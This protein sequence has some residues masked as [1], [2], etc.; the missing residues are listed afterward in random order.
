MVRHVTV[1]T[2]CLLV[3]AQMSSMKAIIKH[4]TLYEISKLLIKNFF[5]DYFYN[6]MYRVNIIIIFIDKRYLMMAERSDV[7]KLKNTFYVIRHG[8]V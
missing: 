2:L 4:F 3:L 5:D 6:I 8:E 7:D 1:Y